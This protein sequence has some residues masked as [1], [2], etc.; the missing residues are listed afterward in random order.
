[1]LLLE[2][3]VAEV[4]YRCELQLAGSLR[5]GAPEE[6]RR[7]DG[8]FENGFANGQAVSQTGVKL[9]SAKV[10]RGRARVIEIQAFELYLLRNQV[11]GGGEH[12]RSANII[13]LRM[14]VPRLTPGFV[15]G[16]RQRE[17]RKLVE[18]ILGRLKQIEPMT[19][20]RPAERQAR[21]KS[22][23]TAQ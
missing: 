4:L 1:A 19:N 5:P 20:E 11:Q 21:G 22:A 16:K 13:E 14:G 8:R 6:F 10:G 12:V 3:I 15:F 7:G 23:D 18:A 9:A 17:D 2:E